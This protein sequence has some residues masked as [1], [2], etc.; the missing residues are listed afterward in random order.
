MLEDVGVALDDMLSGVV[1]AEVHARALSPAVNGQ[2]SKEETERRTYEGVPQCM[3]AETGIE[4]EE[5]ALS[6]EIQEALDRSSRDIGD[7]L[8]HAGG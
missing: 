2:H 3:Q 7:A 1:H 6:V 4:P 8:L 5:P